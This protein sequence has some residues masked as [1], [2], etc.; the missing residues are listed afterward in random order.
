MLEFIQNK[1]GV[2]LEDLLES[3]LS[4]SGLFVQQNNIVYVKMIP[5]DVEQSS[6]T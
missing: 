1:K 2:S 5:E 6:S 4:E 3:L